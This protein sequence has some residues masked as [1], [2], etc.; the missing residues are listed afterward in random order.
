MHVSWFEADAFARWRGARLPT[1]AEWERAARVGGRRRA[2]TSTS[3]TSAPA[4]PARS[5]AT[6]GSGPP[7]S[8]TATRASSAFPYPEYSEVFFGRGYRVLRGASWA[9]RPRV[10]RATFRNWDLP[11]AAPDL[12]RLPLRGGRR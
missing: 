9:T 5:W 8:S 2:A 11:A 1:E 6:A 10:A 4:P 7:A 3:S 12:R